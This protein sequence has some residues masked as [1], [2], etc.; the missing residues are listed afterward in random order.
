MAF[1][2][3]AF[4]DARRCLSFGI[5]CAEEAGDWHLRARLLAT[6]AR[7]DIWV[8]RP[9][10][11]LTETQL[12]LVRAD[13][14]TATEQAML[15]GLEARALARLGRPQETRAAIGRADDAFA[16]QDAAVD[17]A[18]MVFHDAAQQAGDVGAALWDLVAAEAAG[19]ADVAECRARHV[20]AIDRRPAHLARSRAL[21]QIGL[22]K[23]TMAAGDPVEAAALGHAALDAAA[24]LRSRRVADELAEL[25]RLAE[26]HR[27]H[28]EVEDLRERLAAATG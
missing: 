9:D 6:T 24:A 20:T 25:H 16:R 10:Q 12:A 4:E 18:W 3:Y 1:D 23:L 22:A 26:P 19:Q 11:G 5:T 17:P 27:A 2:G 28:S 21:S 15:G 13:R 7:L 8:G 14:L